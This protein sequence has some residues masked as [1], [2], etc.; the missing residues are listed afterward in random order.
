MRRGTERW[1]THGGCA[2]V[3]EEKTLDPSSRLL[4]HGRNNVAVQVAPWSG[5]DASEGRV[6]LAFVLALWSR[7]DFGVLLLLVILCLTRR[8][9]FDRAR[10]SLGLLESL[11]TGENSD[12]PA[13]EEL[14]S[15]ESDDSLAGEEGERRGM[16]G[17]SLLSSVESD[18]F[19]VGELALQDLKKSAAAEPTGTKRDSR[20]AC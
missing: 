12:C 3:Q 17:E 19:Q 7:L 8:I 5:E 9:I 16:A 11:L 15:D 2:T 1:K 10:T 6:V 13:R 20:R 18:R 14:R 4:P